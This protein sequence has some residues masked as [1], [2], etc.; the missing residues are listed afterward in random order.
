M[1]SPQTVTRICV[2]ITAILAQSPQRTQRNTNLHHHCDLCELCLRFL[3]A[4][5]WATFFIA[6]MSS[7]RPGEILCQG[8]TPLGCGNGIKSKFTSPRLTRNERPMTASSLSHS[9][10]CAI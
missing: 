1:F 7:S 2:V 4:R 3:I 6:R 10:N 5:C 8:D 9:I